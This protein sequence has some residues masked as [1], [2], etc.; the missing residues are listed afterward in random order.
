MN[1]L[2]GKVAF[3][4][5]AA[6]GIGGAAASLMAAAGAR[7]AIGDVLE[8]RGRQTVKEIE[9]AGGEVLLA[10]DA[11]ALERARAAFPGPRCCVNPT[12]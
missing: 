2:D 1:R 8:E 12:S 7:V 3:L 4:S 5:G 6:R 9:A 11:A 10:H